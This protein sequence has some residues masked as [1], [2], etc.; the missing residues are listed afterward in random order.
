MKW[1]AIKAKVA[2]GAYTE[3]LQGSYRQENILVDLV[4]SDAAALVEKGLPL[5]SARQ[6]Y[7]DKAYDVIMDWDVR[8]VGRLRELFPRNFPPSLLQGVLVCEYGEG[9]EW[10]VFK[11][12]GV[13]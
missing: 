4:M 2:R 7:A 9:A 6:V 5:S 13:V 1:E 10:E 11:S 12:L 3:T 8:C